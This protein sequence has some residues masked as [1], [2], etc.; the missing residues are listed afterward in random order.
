MGLI[1]SVT[2]LIFPTAIS[3]N[4]V[5]FFYRWPATS[6]TRT[7]RNLIDAFTSLRSRWSSP[8][9]PPGLVLVGGHT[10]MP[11]GCYRHLGSEP[12]AGVT[13]L[14]RV[15]HRQLYTLYRSAEALV[16]PSACEGFAL[17]ILEAMAAG[18]PVIALPLSSIPELGGDAILYADGASP[19]DLALALEQIAMDQSLRDELRRRGPLRAAQFRWEQTARLTAAAYR[20]AV[21]IRPNAH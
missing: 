20:S 1:P 7:C 17:P 8:D 4:T 15:T 11:D 21:S 9:E 18:T 12:P 5:A 3:S 14:G 13:Y 19:R 16:F 6:L 10:S 2:K